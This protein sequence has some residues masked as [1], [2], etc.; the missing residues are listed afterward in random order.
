MVQT[1]TIQ[2]FLP[3]IIA[4]PPELDCYLPIIIFDV[5]EKPA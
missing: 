2:M 3:L 4:K 5:V 1:I